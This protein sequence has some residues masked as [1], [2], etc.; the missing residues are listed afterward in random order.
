[1]K[2][3]TR[4]DINQIKAYIPGKPID[5]VQR[6]FGIKNAI[7]LGSNENAFGAPPKAKLAIKKS[8]NEIFRYPDGSC[9]YLK[10]TLANKLKIKPNNLIFGNGSDELIDIVIKAFLNPGE[11]ILTSKTTFVEYEI[12]ARANGFKAKCL[13]LKDFRYDLNALKSSITK[14]TK[15]IFIANPNNPTGTY[16]TSR[17]LINFLNSI[18]ANMLVVVDEAYIEFVDAKDYPKTLKYFNRRNLIILRTFSKAY[19]LAGLRIGYAIANPDFIKSMERIRQPFNVNFLAQ[20]AAESALRD[21][22]FIK[23]TAKIIRREKNKL[24]KEFRKMGIS[25]IPSQ[26]NF[27]MFKTKM[28]GLVL[29]RKLLKVGIIARD[30]KQYKLDKYVRIT[31]GRPSDNRF[32]VK[33]LKNIILEAR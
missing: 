4:K 32:F 11:E 26:A 24:C 13:P 33:K 23:K 20:R 16:N 8:L 30:L 1:M 2:K 15:V 31:I 29:C 28:E 10:R 9:F 19:G 5:L 18:P 22:S 6:E 27:I 21:V 17:E 12:I 25:Y 14:K 3:I 7:K